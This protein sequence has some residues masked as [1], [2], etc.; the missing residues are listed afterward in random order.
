MT[1][2]IDTL[3][4]KLQQL[5]HLH[6]SGALGAQ[7]Y[8]DART[9]VERQIVDQV[10][11]DGQAVP[12]APVR[13]SRGLQAGLIVGVLALAL[14]GYAYTGAPGFTGAQSPAAAAPVAADDG[15]PPVSDEQVAEIVNRLAQR[16][17]D[18]PDDVAGWALL[19]RAY[20][21]M[22]R[23]A[24]AV[25]AYRKVLTLGG[26]SADL[27]ADYADALGA[28]KNGSLDAEAA[29]LVQRALALEPDNIKATALAGSLAYDRRDYAGAVRQWE[30]VERALPR[31]SRMLG[32]VQASVAQARQLAGLPAL[33]AAA[34]GASAPAVMASASASAS[35]ASAAATAISG[36]VSLA[37]AL[38][39]R[40]APEDTVFV[41]ARAASGPRLPLAVLRKQVKDLPL[42][43][44]LDDSMAMAPNARISDHAQVIVSA[45]ISKSGQAQPQAGDLSGQAAAVA[46]GGRG[47]AVRISEVVGP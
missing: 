38:A 35:A 45:R 5:Q 23:H 33:T 34:A 3:R 42:N 25:P 11:L 37:P 14:A 22:G 16:L 27:L 31:D 47:V 32:Q 12:A 19:A 24:E 21:A 1:P 8:A 44:H 4:H 40:V 30:K 41:F 2:P 10:L 17:K 13:P 28:L 39:A 26:E 9:A 29:Q 43:F 15:S 7:A 20:S 46:P 6:A 36:S 18:Q